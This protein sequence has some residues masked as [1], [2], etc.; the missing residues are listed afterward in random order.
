MQQTC[1]ACCSLPP[2]QLLTGDE[3]EAQ[4]ACVVK[5]SLQKGLFLRD[6]GSLEVTRHPSVSVSFPQLPRVVFSWLQ[7]GILDNGYQVQLFSEASRTARTKLLAAKCLLSLPICTF[8]NCRHV[9][10]AS[11]CIRCPCQGF[12]SRGVASLRRGQ[13]CPMLGMAASSQ[14]WK[15]P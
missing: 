11:M 13:G 4:K 9:S 1:T 5:A 3:E 7:A 6:C 15:A 8:S 2:S 10:P 14:F 12:G